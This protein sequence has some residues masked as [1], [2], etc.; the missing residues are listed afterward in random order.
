[1]SSVQYLTD[2]LAV[3]ASLCMTPLHIMNPTRGNIWKLH[4]PQPDQTAET[5]DLFLS[6]LSCGVR[7]NR[8]IRLSM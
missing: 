7:V 6:L 5:I 1:M 2:S 4:D 3:G 8:Y